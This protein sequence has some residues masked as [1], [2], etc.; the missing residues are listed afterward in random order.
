MGRA[1]DGG[2]RAGSAQS[3]LMVVRIVWG[4]VWSSLQQLPGKHNNSAALETDL[5]AELQAVAKRN[6]ISK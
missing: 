6:A 1:A 3:E 5:I 4:M 2:R